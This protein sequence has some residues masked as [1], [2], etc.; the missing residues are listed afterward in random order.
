M[1]HVVDTLR[2]LCHEIEMI[3]KML[4][5]LHPTQTTFEK[6]ESLVQ[7]ELFGAVHR[8]KQV[9]LAVFDFDFRRKFFVH[10]SREF[11]RQNFPTFSRLSVSLLT[12][13]KEK[14]LCLRGI[15][16]RKEQMSQTTLNR[17]DHRVLKKTDPLTQT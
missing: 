14:E 3:V 16:Q 17:I 7:V 12:A 6:C 5:Q 13:L 15:R 1:T 9:P 4:E 11:Q 8:L 2:T 10:S